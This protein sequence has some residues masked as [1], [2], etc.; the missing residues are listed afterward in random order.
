[1][2]VLSQCLLVFFMLLGVTGFSGAKHK[3]RILVF[4]K[5]AGFHHASIA[6]GNR[7]IMKLGSENKFDVDTTTDAATFTPSN[8]KQYAAIVF[9]S[10][11]GLSTQ[12]FT[13]DE[14]SA[15]VQYIQHGGGYVGIHA[16]TDCCF[17]W[18][19]YGNLSGAY[20]KA[21]PPQQTAIL[22]VTDSTDL[23]TRHLPREWKRRDEW[24]NYK[25]V[26]PGLHVLIKIDEKS[27]NAGPAAMGTEHPMAWYHS[28]DGGRAFYTA[29]GHTE[30]TFGDPLYLQHLLGGIIYAIGKR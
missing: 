9:L 1:M 3:P 18:Q 20:F 5:T 29:L 14:K 2:P 23:S 26:A 11:T 25:W 16:A 12:L 19:W 17:D 30:E 10:T 28:Y 22:N 27:Y 15:M 7:A 21:H 6:A 4:S 24:Y 13:E 8:L